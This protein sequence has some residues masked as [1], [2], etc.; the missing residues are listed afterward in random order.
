MICCYLSQRE[1]PGVCVCV[2]KGKPEETWFNPIFACVIQS[3]IKKD[4]IASLS[5]ELCWQATRE[6]ESTQQA[7]LDPQEDR[8]ETGAGLKNDTMSLTVTA[9]TE[10]GGLF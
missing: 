2:C 9:S 6:C 4:Q 5:T 8:T 7:L 10:R 1:S 3:N